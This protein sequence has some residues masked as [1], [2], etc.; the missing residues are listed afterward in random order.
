[1][2]NTSSDRER[3]YLIKYINRLLNEAS[4]EKVKTV[5]FFVI[6]FLA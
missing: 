6:N 2:N 3:E 5:Y 4:Y 1:M